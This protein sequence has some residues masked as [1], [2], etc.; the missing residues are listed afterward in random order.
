MLPANKAILALEGTRIAERNENRHKTS[1]L[2]FNVST[3]PGNDTGN[4]ASIAI[5]QQ[6]VSVAKRFATKPAATVLYFH[7]RSCGS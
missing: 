1:P 7:V 2:I 5:N 3:T 4:L 6:N